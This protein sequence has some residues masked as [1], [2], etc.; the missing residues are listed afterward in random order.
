MSAASSRWGYAGFFFAGAFLA[1]AF[2]A[3]AFFVGGFFFAGA[4]FFL[5]GAGLRPAVEVG[6][7]SPYRRR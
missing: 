6:W 2:L 7:P 4:T 3:G 5:T 1:G